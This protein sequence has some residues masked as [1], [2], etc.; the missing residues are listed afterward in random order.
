MLFLKQPLF[1]PFLC[2]RSAT[3]CQIDSNKVSKPKL[4]LAL[5]N[6]TVYK[7][8]IIESTAPAQ[9]PRKRSAIF[10]DTPSYSV[11][12]VVDNR[13]FSYSKKESQ[14]NDILLHFVEF[15]NVHNLDRRSDATR[16]NLAYKNV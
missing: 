14:S 9:Q 2:H 4:K 7:T 6:P 13:P 5:S 16:S 10:W 11:V 12:S 8:E 15:S 1:L 3:T